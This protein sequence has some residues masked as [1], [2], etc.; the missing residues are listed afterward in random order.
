MANKVLNLVSF[1]NPYP[2]NYGGAIDVFY[3]IKALKEIGVQVILHCFTKGEFKAH[4]ELLK[5]V[6]TIYFYKTTSPYF[7]FF[8]VVP[9]SVMC[10]TNPKLLQNLKSTNAPILF[11]SLKTTY[12][13]A[14]QELNNQEVYLRL[15]NNEELYYKGLSK[16]ITNYLK[17]I[18]FYLEGV[19]YN[20]F[21]NFY[22]KYNHIFTLSKLETS[23]TEKYTSSVSYIP[24][25]HGNIQIEPLSNQGKYCLYHGDLSIADN[26]K[27]AQFLIKIFKTL[28]HIQLV[29][30]GSKGEK[31]INEWIGKAENINYKK[32]ISNQDLEEL[33]HDAHVNIAWSFQPSG[34]KLKVI[35][36][37]FK[38]RFSI[39][40]SNIVDDQR[41]LDCCTL[42]NSIEDLK[43]AVE[44]LMTKEYTKEIYNARK[45]NLL[46][47]LNDIV[48]AEKLVSYIYK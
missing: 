34:T 45:L 13:V 6:S 4:D 23:Y 2:A 43:E 40:N 30:A 8:S 35:N 1:D 46:E 33:F 14:N 27:V 48:N 20:K 36:A 44:E 10:R 15:H 31:K 7:S 11:E 32:I 22:K 26:L 41:I 9:Y 16:S 29:I 19:K 38:S 28:P 37:L 25:F 47:T 18:I 24:V 17:K 3:K 39:I 5:I 21:N 12:L 42:V